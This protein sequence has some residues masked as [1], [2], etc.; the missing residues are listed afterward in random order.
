MSA[1]GPQSQAEGSPWGF[2]SVKQLLGPRS[3]APARQRLGLQHSPSLAKSSTEHFPDL[4]GGDS[5]T[6]A[7]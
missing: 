5:K 3:P 4:C 2:V 6:A 7:G 1:S